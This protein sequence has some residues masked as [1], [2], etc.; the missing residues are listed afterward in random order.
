MRSIKDRKSTSEDYSQDIRGI[1]ELASSQGPQAK[2]KVYGVISSDINEL[3]QEF[4]CKITQTDT[5]KTLEISSRI[6]EE[7]QF[8]KHSL[9]LFALSLAIHSKFPNCSLSLFTERASEGAI[10]N[11]DV[12]LCID[13]MSLYALKQANISGLTDKMSMTD[14]EFVKS[15]IRNGDWTVNFGPDEVAV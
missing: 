9:Y 15:N 12:S 5:D 7:G 6:L 4:E 3:V 2:L 8:K 14:L 1:G 11:K 10:L 13:E